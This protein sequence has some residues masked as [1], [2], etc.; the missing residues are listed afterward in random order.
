MVQHLLFER[1]WL[2]F[3]TH[4]FISKTKPLESYSGTLDPDVLRHTST[5]AFA[6]LPSTN[7]SLSGMPVI[8][9]KYAEHSLMT[10]S[11]Q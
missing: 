5:R 10:C 8:Y 3:Y 11:Y 2:V 9:K 1:F 7:R 4:L 6:V